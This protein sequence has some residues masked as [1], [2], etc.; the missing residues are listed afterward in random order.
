MV[1]TD[2]GRNWFL[3]WG[4]ALGAASTVSFSPTTPES[5]ANRLGASGVPVLWG[6]V[7][8]LPQRV[9]SAGVGVRSKQQTRCSHTPLPIPSA[10]SVAVPFG[11]CAPGSIATLSAG[12]AKDVRPCLSPPAA[13]QGAG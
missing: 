8:V 6:I 1:C 11:N 7:A 12:Q 10:G 2:D 9:R 4:P 5:L 3:G 13:I